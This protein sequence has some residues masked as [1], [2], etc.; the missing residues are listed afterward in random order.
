MDVVQVAQRYFVGALYH[1]SVH[2]RQFNSRPHM[3]VWSVLAGTH[4]LLV[5]AIRSR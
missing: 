4:A 2:G 3:L 1:L 5:D